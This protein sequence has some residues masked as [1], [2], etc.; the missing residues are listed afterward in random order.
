MYPGSG[1][2]D[3]E[4]DFPLQN[5]RLPF[6][7]VARYGIV[8]PSSGRSGNKNLHGNTHNVWFNFMQFLQIRALEG[9]IGEER[10]DSWNNTWWTKTAIANRGTV[11]STWKKTYEGQPF[12][13]LRYLSYL[14]ITALQTRLLMVKNLEYFCF[15][16]G[17]T[18]SCNCSQE[19]KQILRRNTAHPRW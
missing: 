7:S 17:R 9:K 3:L 2:S 14:D 12:Q 18:Q 11:P 10:K 5:D 1:D 19:S 4:S 6:V 8:L 15:Q 16:I 13:C